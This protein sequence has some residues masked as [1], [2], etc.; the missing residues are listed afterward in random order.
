MYSLL[1][2]YNGYYYTRTTIPPLACGSC[3]SHHYALVVECTILVVVVLICSGSET[4]VLNS[5]L[6]RKMDVHVF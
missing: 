4:Q 5:I 3:N 6:K 2:A 1:L